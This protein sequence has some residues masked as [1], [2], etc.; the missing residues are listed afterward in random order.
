MSLV[1]S[2]KRVSGSTTT[3][4]FFDRSPGLRFYG[5]NEEV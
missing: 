2:A 5:M 3:T 1:L 4:N